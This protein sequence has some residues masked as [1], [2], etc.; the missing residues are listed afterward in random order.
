MLES[1]AR[2]AETG[3][4]VP[5]GFSHERNFDSQVRDFNDIAVEPLIDHLDE[6]LSAET[7][8]LYLFERY[9]RRVLW[10]EQERL[11][12]E[13]S[14]DSSRGEAVYDGDLRQFLFEQ[15]VDFPFSQVASPSGRADITLLDPTDQPLP[16][17]VKLFDGGRYGISYIAKGL[18]QAFRYAEDY[19]QPDGYLVVFNLTVDAIELPTDD[20]AAGWPPRIQIEDRGVFIIVVQASP[21]ASA[22]SAGKQRVHSVQR[23]DLIGLS[24]GGPP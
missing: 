13:Y 4:M 18:G 9:R 15:G 23:S 14:T 10:F 21:C 8:L 20:P 2:N 17:E 24:P 19:D 22:S 1:A 16:L 3:W 11:W 5:D 12:T 7:D 6:R